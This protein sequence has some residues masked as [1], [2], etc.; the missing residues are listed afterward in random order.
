MIKINHIPL[1]KK[2][3]KKIDTPNSRSFLITSKQNM[4]YNNLKR[5][6]IIRLKLKI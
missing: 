6:K 2:I 5:N 3:R 4:N 1:E